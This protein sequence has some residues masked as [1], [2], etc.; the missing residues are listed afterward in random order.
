MTKY[1]IVSSNEKTVKLSI[2][3]FMCG[4]EHTLTVP[5]EGFDKWK[6][7]GVLV[8]KAFPKMPIPEREALTSGMCPKC[9]EDFYKDT[10]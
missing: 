4:K 5:R 3:C 8:Q 10:L 2:P 6:N 1:R 7:G 9:Q